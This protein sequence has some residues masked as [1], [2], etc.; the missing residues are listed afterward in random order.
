M[1]RPGEVESKSRRRR[2]SA[3][4]WLVRFFKNKYSTTDVERARAHAVDPHTMGR[5]PTL[6]GRVSPCWTLESEPYVVPELFRKVAATVTFR[7]SVAE[8]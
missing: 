1:E 6:L 8:V 5:Y 4:H 2:S 3:R 7:V